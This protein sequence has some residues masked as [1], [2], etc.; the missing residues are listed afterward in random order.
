M[1]CS[2]ASQELHYFYSQFVTASPLFQS[3]C[4]VYCS[5]GNL[6]E[7]LLL[8]LCILGDTQMRELLKKCGILGLVGVGVKGKY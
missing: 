5:A 7:P 2:E 1:L 6:Q 8:F 4:S 3:D